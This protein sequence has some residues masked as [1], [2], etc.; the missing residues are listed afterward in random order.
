MKF[1]PSAQERYAAALRETLMRRAAV[2]GIDARLKKSLL[3]ITLF[4]CTCLPETPVSTDFAAF[5]DGLSEV[6]TAK[7]ILHGIFTPAERY[8]NMV[9]LL[10]RKT[11][12]TLVSLLFADAAGTVT[13]VSERKTVTLF[14]EIRRKNP[15]VFPLA[16][17]LGGVAF[18][19]NVSGLAVRFPIVRAID[20]LPVPTAYDYLTDPLSIPNLT[21]LYPTDFPRF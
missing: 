18:Y 7:N 3:Q 17:R 5:F 15:A 4:E 8:G 11:A 16:R 2:F 21:I 12:A 6:L 10:P 14:A 1:L 20:P 13:A 19:F 9:G